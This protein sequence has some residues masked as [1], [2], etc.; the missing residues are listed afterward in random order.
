MPPPTSDASPARHGSL[1]GSR[2]AARHDVS[3]PSSP[4][5]LDLTAHPQPGSSPVEWEQWLRRKAAQRMGAQP[6]EPPSYH[7]APRTRVAASRR[8]WQDFEPQR[9]GYAPLTY[10]FVGSPR[11][12]RAASE[13]ETQLRA[14]LQRLKEDNQRLRAE[15]RD[16]RL[17]VGVAE[18]GPEE[19]EQTELRESVHEALGEVGQ[20][21]DEEKEST[22]HRPEALKAFMP[23][24][25]DPQIK[26][27]AGALHD[28]ELALARSARLSEW[29]QTAAEAKL[30]NETRR[31]AT[32]LKAKITQR[33]A[34]LREPP[35]AEEL[36]A[37]W[38]QLT[39]IVLRKETEAKDA[40]RA[41]SKVA[42][43][44]AKWKNASHWDR[45]RLVIDT[46]I[47]IVSDL[48]EAKAHQIGLIYECA[49]AIID[50]NVDI[51]K[52]Y[53]AVYQV[54]HSGEKQGLKA[55]DEAIAS[56]KTLPSPAV[57]GDP[58]KLRQREAAAD[59]VT[60]LVDAA[61]AKPA[62][63]AV[64][65]AISEQ[66]GA[67][68]E[69]S[70]FGKEEEKDGETIVHTGLKATKRIIEKAELRY[71]E[72]A[73]EYGRTDRVCD[74]VRAMLVAKDM[75]MVRAIVEVLLKLS[76][77]RLIEVVRI[78]DRFKTPSAGGWRDLMVNLVVLQGRGKSAVQ[79]VCEVQVVHEMML[80]ARKGLP[81]HE[82]YRVVRNATEL[83]ESCGL[84]NELRLARVKI[85]RDRSATDRELLQQFEDGWIL[86]DAEWVEEVGSK[87]VLWK[88]LQAG[89][90]GRLINIS[91]R[92]NVNLT[93]LPESVGKFGALQ[94][95]KLH[96]CPGLT[97]LPKRLY[98]CR[99]LHKL[100]LKGCVGLKMLPERLGECEKL[101]E[102]HL[103]NC[104]GLTSLPDLSML[105]DLLKVHDLPEHMQPWEEDGRKG[106][107]SCPRHSLQGLHMQGLQQ[108]GYKLQVIRVSAA[109]TIQAARRRSLRRRESKRSMA[110]LSA[111]D[112]VEAE[113]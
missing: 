75:T 8:S 78:K 37:T 60:L 43:L 66:T 27:A 111:A 85:L 30:R 25:D 79:H 80:T 16:L 3:Q 54:I 90:D 94:T 36:D 104:V 31:L 81:G 113:S 45:H 21:A 108:H 99:A 52:V 62:F 7:A 56:L 23:L 61:A 106:Y 82:I 41:G 91:I 63:D 68:L 92:N 88:G 55:Y 49:H 73:L 84:E 9:N 112:L 50:G 69:S 6:L 13:Q 102:L 97:S 74:V 71:G 51:Q 57:R 10:S 93:S 20:E 28:L 42:E 15:N 59:V 87:E 48:S 83:I 11:S 47:S 107:L 100:S 5:K 89:D 26:Q 70:W 76:E 46:K 96:G 14:Q 17:R 103:A 53:D 29:E 110:R 98:R 58:T 39:D 19:P 32:E 18:S 1:A 40:L 24:A 2:A 77:K 22:D 34:G 105:K 101:R 44:R 67:T 72:A 38:T 95:L 12:G 35:T 65:R 64:V 4:R 86:E 109:T 33:T